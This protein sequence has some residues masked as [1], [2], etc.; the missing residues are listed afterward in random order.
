MITLTKKDIIFA[1]VL[2]PL[3]VLALYGWLGAVPLHREVAGLGEHIA[4]LGSEEALATRRQVLERKLATV[5][6]QLKKAEESAGETPESV[7][8]VSAEENDA[9]RLRRVCDLL[10]G[11]GVRI[12]SCSSASSTAS[13]VDPETGYQPESTGRCADVLK[14]MGVAH[15]SAWR[16]SIEASYPALT[17]MLGEI[18]ARKLPAIPETLSMN[19]GVDA[20]KPEFWT[21]TIWL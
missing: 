19:G 8:V 4:S 11:C 7:A 15:P 9:T 2:P 18:A 21:M 14:Q 5:K 17:K 3:A 13:P 20:D 12:L 16:I 6:E 10:I 1:R